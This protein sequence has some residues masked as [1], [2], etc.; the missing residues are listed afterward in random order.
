MSNEGS[1]ASRLTHERAEMLVTGLP[2][3]TIS[4]LALVSF[5]AAEEA[6]VR[7]ESWKD[8]RENTQTQV[9]G[10]PTCGHVEEEGEDTATV[11]TCPE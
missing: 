5:P 2:S 7:A 1:R 8:R 9:C 10:L 4:R 3:C 11:I 6:K